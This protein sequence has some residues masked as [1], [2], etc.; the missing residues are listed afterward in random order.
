MSGSDRLDDVAVSCVAKWHYCPALRDR[1]LVDAPMT[2]TLVWSLK[3]ESH[4]ADFPV[5]D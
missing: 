2:V 3:D 5:G 4:A 1:A